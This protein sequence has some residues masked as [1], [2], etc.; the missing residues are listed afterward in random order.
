MV[1]EP[2]GSAPDGDRGQLQGSVGGLAGFREIQN[3]QGGCVPYAM[4]RGT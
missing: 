2:P 1:V 3:P 4:V